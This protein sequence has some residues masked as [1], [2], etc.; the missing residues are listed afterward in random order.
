MIHPSLRCPVILVSLALGACSGG[1]SSGG[2]APTVAITS[3]ADGAV[4]TLDFSTGAADIQGTVA[5]TNFKVV[6][7]GQPG[8]GQVWIFVDGSQCNTHSNLGV[9]LPYNT[10]VPSTDP[11]GPM[12]GKSFEAGVDYCFNGPSA[13]IHITGPH[14]IAAELHRSDGSA[15]QV[16]GKTVSAS[17]GVTVQLAPTDGG[18]DAG[19]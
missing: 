8:D 4:L 9:L 13:G 5:T 14:Q 16:D 10:T 2:P 17:V 15:V 12:D 6:P 18:T 19:G 11:G 7:V 1:G 3:P